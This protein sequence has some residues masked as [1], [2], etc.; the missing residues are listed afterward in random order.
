[1]KSSG[2]N[3]R[4][5]RLVVA[6]DGSS[7]HG[8][9]PNRDVPTVAGA[10]TEALE[11]ITQV[12]V[13]L[14]VAGRTDAGVHARAQVVSVELPTRT[15]IDSL[16]KKL[17]ALCGPRIAVRDAAWVPASFHARFSA[18]WRHYRYTILN[19]ATLTRSWRRPRGTCTHPST[20]ARCNSRRT[21]SWASV[22]FLRFAASPKPTKKTNTTARDQR[23]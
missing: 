17:N 9:A 2:A 15:K 7:F 3:V 13:H 12:P 18:I 1:M 22:T 20:C 11:K 16:A 23:R 6:Y 8:F 4:N 19:S 14:V 21:R 10:L 5:A